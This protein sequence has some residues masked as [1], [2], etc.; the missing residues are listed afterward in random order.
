MQRPPLLL[1]QQHLQLQQ[2]QRRLLPL[3]AVHQPAGTLLVTQAA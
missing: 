3:L 2:W 1:Q